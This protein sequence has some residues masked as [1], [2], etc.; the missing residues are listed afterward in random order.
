MKNGHDNVMKMPEKGCEN[1][2][3]N[4]EEVMKTPERYRYSAHT[5]MERNTVPFVIYYLLFSVRYFHSKSSS[6]HFYSV[7]I[8]SIPHGCF[9]RIFS[10]ISGTVHPVRT[11]ER[12][13]QENEGMPHSAVLPVWYSISADYSSGIP[14]E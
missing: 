9:W 7:L 8:L 14:Q 12:V 6:D 11:D 1:T 5:C 10:N 13:S 2:I 3:K 4:H